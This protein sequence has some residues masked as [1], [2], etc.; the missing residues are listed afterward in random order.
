M[1]KITNKQVDKWINGFINKMKKEY[2]PEKM[3]VFGSRSHGTNLL[4]SDLDIII[5]SKKFKGINW[6]QRISNVSQFWDGMISLDPLCYTPEEFEKKSK[7][8]CIVRE[9]LVS[10][11]LV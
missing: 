9:A 1:D 7:Q 2:S 5:V 6:L 10:G 11:K 4:T 3:I 8:I